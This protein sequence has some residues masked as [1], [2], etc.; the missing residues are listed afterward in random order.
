MSQESL[1]ESYESFTEN[2]LTRVRRPEEI[3]G[4]YEAMKFTTNIAESIDYE[5]FGQE[6]CESEF[7]ETYMMRSRTYKDNQ[8]RQK[9]GII[10]RYI[11]Y[12]VYIIPY[13]FY[14]KN[15]T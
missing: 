3:P 6:K 10:I 8:P 11:I 1:H 12:M 5:D 15:Y 13:K 4:Y 7:I 9:S 14:R 2:E